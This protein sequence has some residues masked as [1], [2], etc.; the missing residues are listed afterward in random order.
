MT[1]A[2]QIAQELRLLSDFDLL[3][4]FMS[5]LDGCGTGTDPYSQITRCIREN[6]GPARAAALAEIERISE[7]MARE[8]AADAELIAVVG[9]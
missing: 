4:S 6:L 8:E 2:R 9:E 1:R 5:E 7:R 3:D